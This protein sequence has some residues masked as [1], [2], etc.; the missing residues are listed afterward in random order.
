[1][2]Q[3]ADP[4]PQ[5]ILVVDDNESLRVLVVRVLETA[6]HPTEAVGD[7]EAALARLGRGDCLAVVLDHRL[8]G[9]SGL[10]LVA[11]LR[12]RWTAEQL[13]VVLVTGDDLAVAGRRWLEAGATDCLLK[14]FDAD[15]L[16][17]TVEA[18]L[19]RRST[20]RSL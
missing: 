4:D 1:M 6:G 14:P 17:T 8:P 13:P 18:A 11:E 3:G 10:D 16:L 5:P 7:A 12:R 2:E 15:A 20:V 9:M 19:A